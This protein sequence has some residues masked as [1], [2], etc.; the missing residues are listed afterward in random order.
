MTSHHFQFLET[1]W[2]LLLEAATKAESLAN[3]DARAACFYARR[4]LDWRWRGYTNMTR[5]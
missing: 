1:E 5:H 3:S 4:G 2:P